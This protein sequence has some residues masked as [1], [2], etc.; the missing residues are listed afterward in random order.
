MRLLEKK[1][2]NKLLYSLVVCALILISGSLILAYHALLLYDLEDS[3]ITPLVQ[4]GYLILLTSAICLILIAVLSWSFKHRMFQNGW[5]YAFHHSQLIAKIRRALLE[6][7]FFIREKNGYL[8]RLPKI[9][10]NFSDEL[11]KGTLTIQNHIKLEKPLD[12]VNI[13][14]AL[15]DF[16]VDQFY[17]DDQE[18]NFIYDIFDTKKQKQ[19]IFQSADEFISYSQER[20]SNYELFIDEA[21]RIGLHHLLLCGATGSGKTYFL[22]SYILQA[23]SK[24]IKYNL[25]FA[26]P[27]ASSL[28]VLGHKISEENTAR[29]V[30]GIIT[31]LKRCH[32]EMEQRKAVIEEKLNEKLDATYETFNLSPT[33]FICDEWASAQ[34]YISTMPK[35]DRDEVSAILKAIVMQGRQLGFF[36]LLV[37]QQSNATTLSTDIRDN[38]ICK[39]CVGQNDKSTL[40]TCFGASGASNVRKRRYSVGQGVFCYSGLTHQDK[41]KLLH[42]PKL[43]FDILDAVKAL[44][45]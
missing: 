20:C 15:D 2:R 33:I 42:V 19:L 39:I 37:T 21:S 36:I 7:G 6:G 35:K 13:S 16:V 41:P 17:L 3:F 25:Y 44:L 10:L 8:V 22:Y 40:E 27:K 11:A 5:R 43:D 12:S 31:L 45:K 30:E 1:Q 24:P 26:D 34:A 4:Q 9:T 18:N 29:D 32:S 38:L 28:A 14:S 23:L